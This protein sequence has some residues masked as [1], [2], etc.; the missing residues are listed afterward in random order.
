MIGNPT[1]LNY[2]G[3]RSHHFGTSNHTKNDTTT[4]QTVIAALR[5]R[6]K[7]ICEYCGRTGHKNYAWI[8]LGTN[9]LPPSIR[10][11]INQFNALHVNETNDP[12]R[13]WNIQT[14]AV[15]FKYRTSPPKTSFLFLSIIGRLNHHT[16]DNGDADFH[17]SEY[18]FEYNSEDVPY[19]DTTPIKS[20]GNGEMEKILQFFHSEHDYDILD[21]DLQMIQDLLLVGY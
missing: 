2:S 6:Q 20:V 17:P 15:H 18:P 14:P 8:I 5:V 7:I 12:P 1:S 13:E 16:V 10:R 19:Q 4:L 9:F 21:I 11:N 3:Q